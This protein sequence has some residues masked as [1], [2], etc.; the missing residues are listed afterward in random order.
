M[1]NK[2]LIAES[3]DDIR[4][5]LEELFEEDFEVLS[6]SDGNQAIEKLLDAKDE[7]AAA[8]LDFDLSPSASDIIVKMAETSWFNEVPFIVLSENVSLKSEKAVYAAGGT[9]FL[10][11]PFDSALLKKKVSKYAELFAVKTNLDAVKSTISKNSSNIEGNADVEKMKDE[12]KRMNSNMIELIGTL[13]EF[14]NSE[15]RLHVSR[16]KGLVKIMGKTVMN[17]Y[18]EY[19]LNENKVNDIVD[20]CS[21][22]DIGKIAISDTILLKP[23]RLTDE[24]YELMK[25]HPLR[26]I[27]ILE[28]VSGVWNDDFSKTAAKII[29]SH[30]E[31]FDGGG[32]P[33]GL[34]GEAIPIEASIVS[35][36]DTYDALVNDRVY[37]KAFPKDVAFNMIISGDCGVFA[38]KILEA[39]TQCRKKWEDWEDRKLNF[40]DL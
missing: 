30:H 15:N 40:K 23:G 37:K 5:I 14:R 35:I 29:R 4:E 11:V 19:G 1:K 34:R 7:L 18:P 32:Y 2:I 13:V 24:E 20:A 9:D 8:L 26:G 27:E 28:S 16:M 33:D 25:S 22:H 3:N 31:K 6:A 10:K 17:L 39:L 12:Y 36:A 21:I 38:P